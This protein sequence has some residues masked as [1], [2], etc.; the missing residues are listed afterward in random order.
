MKHQDTSLNNNERRKFSRRDVITAAVII[1][2]AL[3]VY[4]ILKCV[5]ASGRWKGY[6]VISADGDVIARLPLSA[7]TVYRPEN[8][9][10]EFTV[11]DGRVCV[12]D[13]GCPDK[14]CMHKGYISGNFE[15]IVCLP[16]KIT[17]TIRNN[18]ENVNTESNI[19]VIL[20]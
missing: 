20:N 15:S 5:G 9:D 2:S 11:K 13:A 3:A 6:A 17:V 12:S 7:D 1:I 14:I 19:D 18:K 16:Q 10:I 8:Y 4:F